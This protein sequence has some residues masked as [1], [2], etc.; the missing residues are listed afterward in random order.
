VTIHVGDGRPSKATPERIEAILEALRGGATRQAA[1]GF[2]DVH[3]ATMAR[4]VGDNVDFRAAV[5]NAEQAAEAYYTSVVYKASQD[6]WQAAAW[7]LERRKFRDYARRDRVDVSVEV[8]QEMDRLAAETGMDADDL[9]AEAERV[10]SEA[11][12]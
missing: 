6:N 3:Y 11:R 12:R 9:V 4:W 10:L 8:R 2:A 5:E 7:W 1:A